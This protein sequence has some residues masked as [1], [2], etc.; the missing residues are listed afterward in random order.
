MTRIRLGALVDFAEGLT[1]VSVAGME[2]AV[3]RTP[4]G[5]FALE[6]RCTHADC[7]LSEGVLEEGAVICPCHGSEFDL[8]TGNVLRPPAVTPVRAFGTEVEVSDLYLVL[9]QLDA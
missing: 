4:D 7:A 8:K 3:A 2:V 5:I 1:A 6:D 9:P